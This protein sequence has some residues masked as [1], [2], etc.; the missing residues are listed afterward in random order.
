MFLDQLRFTFK[1]LNYQTEAVDSIVR[2]F[3]GQEFNDG[4]LY[5]HDIGNQKV[6]QATID[7]ETGLPFTDFT[8]AYRNNDLLVPAEILLKNINAIQKIHGIPLSKSIV[9]TLGVNSAP[10]F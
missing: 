4:I 7:P 3:E 9:H 1:T 5:R 10:L 8:T 2:I 6:S